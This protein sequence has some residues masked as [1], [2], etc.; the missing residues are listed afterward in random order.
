M[1]PRTMLIVKPPEYMRRET[2]I[3]TI[4]VLNVRYVWLVFR[5]LEQHSDN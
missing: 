4:L 1:S 3:D 2:R 5:L